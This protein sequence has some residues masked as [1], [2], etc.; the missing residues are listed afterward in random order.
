[1]HKKMI[2]LIF[3][4]LLFISLVSNVWINAKDEK[5]FAVTSSDSISNRIE[6]GSFENPVISG[7]YQ[8]PTKDKV[9]YWNTTAY[10]TTGE[11]GMIE[12]FKENTG[13][14]IP[15]IKLT[16]TDGL[17]AAELNADEESSL[18]QIVKTTPSSA[19]LWGLDHR[20][21]SGIDTM[22]LVIGPE[23][24]V[25]PSKNKGSGYDAKGN[26]FENSY[27]YGKDQMMQMVDWLKEKGI[28]TPDNTDHVEKVT[29]YSKKF[30]A[31]GQFQN[32]EDNMP[33]SMSYSDIYSQKWVIW[34]IA[35]NNDQWYSYGNNNNSDVPVNDYGNLDAS[36]V[37]SSYFYQVPAGQTETMFSFVSVDTAQ[38]K[39]N[40]N[41]TIGNLLDH[42]N[43]Q[44]YN[45]MTGSST[46]HGSAS[47]SNSYITELNPGDEDITKDHSVIVYTLSGSSENL[48]AKIKKEDEE[49]VSFAGAYITK[50]VWDS[51]GQII[52]ETQFLARDG[53]EMNQDEALELNDWQ[54]MSQLNGTKTYQSASTQWI[55]EVDENGNTSYIYPQKW[56]KSIDSDGNIFYT[57]QLTNITYAFDAHFIFLKCPTITY[58]TN[59]GK[60]Y[61]ISSSN[62]TDTYDFQPLESDGGIQYIAPYQSHVSEGQNENW[63]FHG[64][65]VADD[66]GIVKNKE[67]QNLIINGVHSI[68]CNYQNAVGE[69]SKQEFVIINGINDFT[70]SGPTVI[71]GVISGQQW[72]TDS[73]IIYQKKASGLTLIAQWS[74]KQIF[75]PQLQSGNDYQDCKVGG[76]VEIKKGNDK[77][78]VDTT[79]GSQYCYGK[80]NEVIEVEAIPNE[81]YTFE[82]WYDQD[83]QLLTQNVSLDVTQLKGQTKT[84]YARFSLKYTQ[85][86]IRQ[87][88]NENGVWIDT[89]DD[90]IATLTSYENIGSIGQLSVA[91]A[92]EKG[93]YKLVGWYDSKGNKVD[94]NL[95]TG[96]TLSYLITGHAIYYARFEPS[97]II[98]FIAQTESS[99]GNYVDSTTG[100]VVDPESIKYFDDTQVSSK[101]SQKETYD[102]I[103]WYDASGNRLS[104]NKEY[105]FNVSAQDDEKTYYARFKRHRYTVN[106]VSYTKDGNGSYVENGPGGTVSPKNITGVNGEKVTSKATGHPGYKFVG[107]YTSYSNMT[108]NKSGSTSLTYSPTI[109]K[110]NATYY[111]LFEDDRSLKVSKSVTGN[112]GDLNKQFEIT[113]QIENIGTKYEYTVYDAKG[114]S[115]DNQVLMSTV[116]NCTEFRFTLADGEYIVFNHLPGQAKYEVSEGDY[117]QENY[118]TSYLVYDENDELLFNENSQSGTLDNNRHVVI[119]NHNQTVVPP[120]GI[121]NDFTWIWLVLFIILVVPIIM[122]KRIITRK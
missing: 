14:Y 56:V 77:G 72:M 98:Y 18:Y 64:W 87:I 84:Y 25:A 80:T 7:T 30:A 97:H 40:G 45:C 51:S 59:G 113:V 93:K 68:A 31:N 63:K 82:G 39:I 52:T 61:E 34:V 105:T 112:M 54:L 66:D 90:N 71:D 55:K 27:K 81:R 114:D 67:G 65:I 24:K 43:F 79:I 21:R 10:N 107:W 22:A 101:A 53:N 76:T 23:Q 85:R 19:Y 9:P 15:N 74:W 122:K 41:T 6:N 108:G 42:V 29:L 103:G 49:R 47:L 111:A 37:N 83:G 16:P 95:V 86:F 73:S 117:S 8:Q 102:F 89:E 78:Y 1:M 4:L 106:F 38:R 92:N 100:G 120:T 60:P 3:I 75:I 5:A 121:K 110:A 96:N 118:Q 119:T 91:S 50:Q 69:D 48:V 104:T 58:D 62:E 2:N 88:K 13:T 26:Y 70:T 35:S 94:D 99:S 32:N 20:G 11:N 57:Y 36:T 12:F 44:I 116:D 17:Q 28:I 33:F 46:D 109:N 115:I